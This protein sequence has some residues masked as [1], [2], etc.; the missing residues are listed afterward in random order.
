MPDNYLPWGSAPPHEEQERDF[1]RADKRVEDVVRTVVEKGSHMDPGSTWF[2]ETIHPA[3]FYRL[4][5]AMI[6]S[7]DRAFYLNDE[8][9]GCLSCAKTCPVENITMVDKHPTWGGHCQQCLACAQWCNKAAIE[10]N[11]KSPE[12]TRYHHPEIKRKQIIKQKVLPKQ[13]LP[14]CQISKT[15]PGL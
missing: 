5:Y 15:L 7:S 10:V 13:K 9:V 14:Q 8:C 1:V 3:L 12:Y 6:P 4:G 2:K 11:K